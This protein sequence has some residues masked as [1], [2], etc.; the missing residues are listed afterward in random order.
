MLGVKAYVDVRSKYA[1]HS[2]AVSEELKKLGAVIY[3]KL[4]PTVTHVIFK[5]GSK[6]TEVKAHKYGAHLVSV[7]WVDRY[8]FQ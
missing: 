1:N 7:N 6:A 3:G 4:L 8:I 5:D 2:G